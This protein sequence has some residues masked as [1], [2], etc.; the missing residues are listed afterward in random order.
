MLSL[1]RALTVASVLL[2]PVLLPAQNPRVGAPA[3]QFTA[4]DSLG[5]M[6]TLAENRGKYVVLE[7]HNNGCPYTRKHYV[8]GNMQELQKN[9]TGK[10]VVWLTVISSSPGTQGYV[11]AAEENDYLKKMHAAPTAA[12]LDPDGQI[13]HLYGAK[14]TP[15]MYV[16]NPEGM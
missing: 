12:I 3:P 15:E 1:S 5:R 8:S 2:L 16:I 14:T 13:G 4:A 10:G 7:W 9:W 6:Q 11:T